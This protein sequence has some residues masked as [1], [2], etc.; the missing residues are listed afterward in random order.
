MSWYSYHSEERLH[1]S[2]VSHAALSFAS[3]PLYIIVPDSVITCSLKVATF[4]NKVKSRWFD[5]SDKISGG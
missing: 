3:V 4:G 5:T 1:H 2:K